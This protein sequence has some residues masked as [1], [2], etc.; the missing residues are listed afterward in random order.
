MDI[1]LLIHQY[2]YLAIAVGSFF[3]GEAVLLAGTVAAYHGHLVLPVVFLLA[4]LFSFLG[5]QPY[6]FGGRRYGPA[7]LARCPSLVARKDRVDALL[8]KHQV[9]L[10][11]SLRFLYGLRVAGLIA[12]GMSRMSPARFLALDFIGA[13]IWASTV[14]AAG[15]G[16][17]RLLDEMLAALERDAAQLTLLAALL[18]GSSLLIIVSRRRRLAPQRARRD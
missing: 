1:S 16:L 10:V 11:L 17:G 2:G 6:F 3:E 15:L 4:A 7:M 8:E 13:L 9:L 5:D 18:L 14:T 12:L